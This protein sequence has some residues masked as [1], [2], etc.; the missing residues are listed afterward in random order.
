MK[1]IL[2]DFTVVRPLAFSEH[3]RKLP[4]EKNTESLN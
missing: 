1:Y 4:S 3:Y 2:R